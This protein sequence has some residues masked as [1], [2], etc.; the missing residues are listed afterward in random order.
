MTDINLLPS[1]KRVRDLKEK[2]LNLKE[3]QKVNFDFN[4]PKKDLVSSSLL[5]DTKFKKV[6]FLDRFREWRKKRKQ[7]AGSRKQEKILQ[8]KEEQKKKEQEQKKETPKESNLDL[9]RFH[10]KPEIKQEIKPEIKPEIKTKQ[11][12]FNEVD[13]SNK[14]ISQHEHNEKMKY[15]YGKEIENGFDVNLMPEAKQILEITARFKIII[16]L[17]VLIASIGAWSGLFFWFDSQIAKEMQNVTSFDKK[18]KDLNG[19]IKGTKDNQKDVVI[20]QKRMVVLSNLMEEHIYTSHI[21]EYLEKNV[22]PGVYFETIDV[23]VINGRLNID[24]VAR[25]YTEAAKQILV[26]EEDDENILMMNIS[27][28]NLNEKKSD[29]ADE[30]EKSEKFVKFNLGIVLN[31]SFFNR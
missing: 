6:S 21:F 4:E 11:E 12:L 10:I 3:K 24:S 15:T 9:S 18:I 27:N 16:L 31:S 13:L 19:K 30:Q 2:E 17:A 25:D 23:D 28:L 26:F 5:D 14:K 20:F 8:K 7:K 22:V 29:T 1:D